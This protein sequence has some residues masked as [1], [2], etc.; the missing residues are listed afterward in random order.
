MCERFIPSFY[1]IDL[2]IKLQRMYQG[3]RSVEVYFK[4]ME[5]WYN[6]YPNISSSWKG[7]E[8][9]EDKPRRDKGVHPQTA[10]KKR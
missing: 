2:F 9:R 8:R 6:I 3:F 10:E 7:K 4:E 5:A 1:T